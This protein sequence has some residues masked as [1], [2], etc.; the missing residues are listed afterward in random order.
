MAYQIDVILV[1]RTNYTSDDK[2]QLDTQTKSKDSTIY[3][4]SGNSKEIIKEATG[5]PSEDLAEKDT[6]HTTNGFVGAFATVDELA[7]NDPTIKSEAVREVK[8]HENTKRDSVTKIP[9]NSKTHPT[10]K[11]ATKKPKQNTKATTGN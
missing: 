8:P 10:P 7:V 1:S 2:K 3:S 9:L 5:G 6:K 4:T 11:K